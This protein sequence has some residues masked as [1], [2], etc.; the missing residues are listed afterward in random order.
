MSGY[1]KHAAFAMCIIVAGWCSSFSEIYRSST[2]VIS[3]VLIYIEFELQQKSNQLA[4]CR[5]DFRE[6]QVKVPEKTDYY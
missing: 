2:K 5:R 6:I 1:N 3:N 4:N